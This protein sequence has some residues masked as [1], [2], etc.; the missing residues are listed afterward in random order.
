LSIYN[1]FYQKLAVSVRI[2]QLPVGILF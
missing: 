2:P 1:L